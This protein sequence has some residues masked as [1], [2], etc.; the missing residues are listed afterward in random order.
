MRLSALTSELHLI[1]FD[2]EMAR[3]KI[4]TA[5]ALNI[6]SLS[7]SAFVIFFSVWALFAYFLH[8]F[9]VL[10]R[11]YVILFCC[12]MAAQELLAPPLIYNEFHFYSHWLGR[13][14]WVFFLGV[15]CIGPSGFPLVTGIIIWAIAVL[16]V[17]LHFLKVPIPGAM[18][19]KQG[20]HSSYSVSQEPDYV[21]YAPI[22]TRDDV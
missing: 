16:F 14:I 3:L 17:V 13:G 21:Q 8:W 20:S 11:L 15:L 6:L 4:S 12:M 7:L 9:N 18:L 2:E 19:Q 22:D 5:L 1:S 10:L